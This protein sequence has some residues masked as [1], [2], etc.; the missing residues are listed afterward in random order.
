M[1]TSGGVT[2]LAAHDDFRGGFQRG[3]ARL[4]GRLQLQGRDTSRRCRL[5]VYN[6]L[7]AAIRQQVFIFADSARC[8]FSV[9]E[10]FFISARGLRA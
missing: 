8:S 5:P 9:D 2:S 1:K 7:Y 10:I 3:S 6:A 4:V